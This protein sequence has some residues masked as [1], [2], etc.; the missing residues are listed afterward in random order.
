MVTIKFMGFSNNKILTN[1]IL[2]NK[3]KN[4]KLIYDFYKHEGYFRCNA[5][6]KHKYIHNF[7][8][9]DMYISVCPI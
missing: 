9:V 2:I 4:S 7:M 1:I 6:K 5:Y 8:F 3:N